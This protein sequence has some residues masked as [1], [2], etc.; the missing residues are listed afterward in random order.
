MGED[1]GDFKEQKTF[2]ASAIQQAGVFYISYE[3]QSH[4]M[5]TQAV[6]LYFNF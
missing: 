5:C 6:Q 4:L 2:M 1:D 3:T